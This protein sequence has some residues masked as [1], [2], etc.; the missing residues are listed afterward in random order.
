MFI[1]NIK[2]NYNVK[3]LDDLFANQKY[4]DSVLLLQSFSKKN[5]Q[6]YLKLLNYTIQKYLK[7]NNHLNFFKQKFVWIN[8]FDFDDTKYFNKFLNYYFSNLNSFSYLQ[9]SYTYLL[10]SVLDDLNIPDIPKFISFDEI[11][12]N[13]Y[14]F[15][16]I[17]LMNST[18][19]IF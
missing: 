9:G 16:L 6:L 3:I 11:V 15:Q 4:E 2:F 14:L 17:I 18:K 13:S 19:I 8:S 5:H 10:S 12:L 1:N 7:N